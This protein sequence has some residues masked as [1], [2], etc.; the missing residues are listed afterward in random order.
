MSSTSNSRAGLSASGERPQALAE[1]ADSV[2]AYIRQHGTLPAERK[3]AEE[4]SVKRHQ[5]RRALKLLQN[6]GEMVRETAPRTPRSRSNSQ[7][8]GQVAQ[9]SNPLE[10]IELRLMIEPTL[11]RLAALRATP[12]MIAAIRRAAASDKRTSPE[13][14]I[15]RLIAVA[16]GNTVAAEIQQLLEKIATEIEG[17]REPGAPGEHL[18]VAQAIADRDPEAA[19]RE[20][21]AHLAN[22]HTQINTAHF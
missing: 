15:H 21:R 12:P 11:A 19:E 3:L 20:M 22:L 10:V 16:S 18:P 5:L 4:L 6:S 17:D 9:N 7:F 14:S 2:R 13:T 1:L 8:A